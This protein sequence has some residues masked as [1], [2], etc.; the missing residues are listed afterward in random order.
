MFSEM[1]IV[2]ILVM[3]F[4]K[5]KAGI[6]QGWIWNIL[7]PCR[8]QNP[9][10]VGQYRPLF[11]FQLGYIFVVHVLPLVV[12]NES[13]N[14]INSNCACCDLKLFLNPAQYSSVV[15][16]LHLHLVF[17]NCLFSNIF[18]QSWEPR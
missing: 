10:S 8:V 11:T 1:K 6:Q 16:N 2:N 14:S 17:K 3:N 13:L 5:E 7:F 9:I 15:F 18:K 4:L 12:R